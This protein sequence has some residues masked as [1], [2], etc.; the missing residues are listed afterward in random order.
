PVGP[1]VEY[2][3]EKA[4]DPLELR[5]YRGADG[6]FT[7]YEDEG[8][9]YDY[10]KGIFAAI[11]IHWNDAGRTLTISDRKGEFPGMLQSRRFHVVLVT[12]NH[13]AGIGQNKN[14]DKTLQYDGH[15]TTASF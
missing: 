10:E 8:D 6:D 5:I 13:G 1:D 15:T 7:L 9:S 4:A 3:S 2:A 14:P 12:A 11:S